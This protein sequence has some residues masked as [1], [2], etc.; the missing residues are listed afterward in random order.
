MHGT[1]TADLA[2][3]GRQERFLIGLP[4]ICWPQR[5]DELASKIA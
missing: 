2:Q 1:E 3:V 4:K 5:Q